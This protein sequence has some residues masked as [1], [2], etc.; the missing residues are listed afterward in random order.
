MISQRISFLKN[1][2]CFFLIA[3][4]KQQRFCLIFLY[5]LN[6]SFNF[7]SILKF[8]N[9]LLPVIKLMNNFIFQSSLNGLMIQTKEKEVINFVLKYLL[10]FQTLKINK[11][12][13]FVLLL[14]DETHVRQF[15][16]CF[17]AG[18]F[19]EREDCFLL[20]HFQETFK[21]ICL[22]VLRQLRIRNVNKVNLQIS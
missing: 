7:V 18:C 20:V 4:D 8:C 3:N 10:L 17:F 6:E 11:F 13:I 12:L 21:Q 14:R 1:N 2:S 15:R 19:K 9:P 16:E 22:E 5:F